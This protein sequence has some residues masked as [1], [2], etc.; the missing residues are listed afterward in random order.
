M[1]THENTSLTER[2]RHEAD[3][4][5][6]VANAG[7]AMTKGDHVVGAHVVDALG[8]AELLATAA[9]AVETA[10][11]GTCATCKHW[12]KKDREKIAELY[13][14]GCDPG[15]GPYWS[16]YCSEMLFEGLEIEIRSGD[17]SFDIRTDDNFGCIH[18][19]KAEEAKS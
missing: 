19:A 14:N 5:V 7:I 10:E 12:P 11:P 1:T 2:L 16:G 18:Y 6:R 4:F 9:D 17:A 8:L 15:K 3:D 13:A